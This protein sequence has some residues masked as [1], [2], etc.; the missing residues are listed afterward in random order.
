MVSPTLVEQYRADVAELTGLA[1]Q[2]LEALWRQVSDGDTARD[3]LLDVLP[4]LVALYGSAAATLGAD[5][6]D[7][8]RDQTEIRGRFRAIPADLPDSGR[9]DALARWGVGPLFTP[10]PDLASSLV[11]VQGGLQRI[12]ADAAR[13]TVALSSVADPGA[14]GWQRVGVGANCTFC[15]MLI[16][17][18]SVY[19]EAGADFASH[20]HCNCAAAP[21]FKGVP[22][23]VKPYTPSLQGST[24]ADRARVRE[25][26]RT[27]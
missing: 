21:A 25:Y 10:N 20:D 23:P 17:R 8:A 3:L 22:R 24:E 6:Y 13:Q 15:S 4:E 11:L 1:E 7:E 5:W 12:V 14:D 26:L 19:S 18:G 16:G 27:H 9:T 2:D